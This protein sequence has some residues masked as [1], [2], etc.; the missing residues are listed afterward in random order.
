MQKKPSGGF[1]VNFV[2]I[3]DGT[4]S[5]QNVNFEPE[6]EKLFVIISIT[7]NA[8]SVALKISFEPILCVN[9]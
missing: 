3:G 6:K 9:V 5:F 8:D 1:V 2:I 7:L 4:R